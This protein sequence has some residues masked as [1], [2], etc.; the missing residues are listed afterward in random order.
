MES[1]TALKSKRLSN[2]YKEKNLEVNPE[3]ELIGIGKIISTKL[4][5]FFLGI[6]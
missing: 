2:P 4:L 6:L 3:P 1:N 5:R